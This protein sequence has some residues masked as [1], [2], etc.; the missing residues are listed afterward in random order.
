MKTVVEHIVSGKANSGVW[1]GL[2]EISNRAQED[3]VVEPTTPAQRKFDRREVG[4]PDWSTIKLVPKGA[5]LAIPIAIHEAHRPK[6]NVKTAIHAVRWFWASPSRQQRQHLRAV[7][8]ELVE[9]SWTPR[10]TKVKA[11]CRASEL[12]RFSSRG[13]GLGSAG[14]FKSPLATVI[15]LQSHMCSNRGPQCDVQGHP[16]GHARRILEGQWDRPMSQRSRR[17]G[18]GNAA[19]SIVQCGTNHPGKV[20]MSP[21]PHHPS[22]SRT[23]LGTPCPAASGRD[24]PVIYLGW[25]C[26][27][28]GARPHLSGGCKGT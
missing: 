24:L 5:S 17:T 26:H 22:M 21:R 18:T 19:L 23:Y 15:D 8:V 10:E 28:P 14:S 9:P 2:R 4:T 13:L 27:H 11:S 6:V 20:S 12:G 25:W 1:A 16:W 3:Q 7:Y